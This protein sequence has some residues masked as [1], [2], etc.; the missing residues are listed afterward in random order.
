MGLFNKNKYI[1]ITKEELQSVIKGVTI[2]DL[3][4]SGGTTI[5]S[6]ISTGNA[7]SNSIWVYVCSNKISRNIARIPLQ[8]YKN[9]KLITSDKDPVVELFNRVNPFTNQYQLIEGTELYKQINGNTY[10]HLITDR[11]RVLEIELLDPNKVQIAVDT[12]NNIVEYIYNGVNH[13]SV[14]EVLHF[15]Y[16]NPFNKLYG[17]NPVTVAMLSLL[18]NDLARQYVAN[19]YKNFGQVG[20]VLETSDELNDDIFNRI[21]K[22]FESR[23]KGSENAGKV[24]LLESGV[25]Y[26]ETKISLTD[27][28]FIEQKNITKSE[29]HAIYD[30]NMGL[31]GDTGTYNKANLI[32]ITKDFWTQKLIPEMKYIE[33]VINS[34]MFD[35]YFKGYS[36]EFDY[37]KIDALQ[38]DI[39]NVIRSANILYQMG[40]TANEINDRL[41]LGFDNIPSRDIPYSE[42]Q[43][44]N[45]APTKEPDTIDTKDSNVDISKLKSKI[46]RFM[47]EIRKDVLK[48]YNTNNNL[49]VDKDALLNKFIKL[50]IPT[51]IE[52]SDTHTDKDI[53]SGSY[54]DYLKSKTT[55]L[56]DIFNSFIFELNAISIDKDTESN[57]KKLTNNWQSSSEVL[58]KSLI[59]DILE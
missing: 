50:T 19:I 46:K 35:K 9:N 59:K 22:Q 45:S 40:F 15:K 7:Y 49:S 28:Q 17:F 21:V 54:V 34:N 12:N 52:L 38:T 41:E 24:A 27:L 56:T 18:P 25:K 57:I 20:G 10:W 43:C 33:D 58:A 47:F 5:A 29:I 2:N 23:H 44:N 55:E 13:L 37:S 51:I 16:F 39:S 11:D 36:I 30:V 14:D 3:F 31:T 26:K 8:V 6:K 48:Q 4:N 32:Q 53:N 1:K 42:I